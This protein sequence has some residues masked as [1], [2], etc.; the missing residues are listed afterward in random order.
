V[1]L[2]L[3]RV[4]HRDAA[5]HKVIEMTLAELRLKY[6][7]MLRLRL[8]H[9]GADEP[10]PRRDMATLAGRFPGALREIDELP[11]DEIEAR[12]AAID[13]AVIEPGLAAPWMTAMGLYH[14]LTRGALCA[15]RWLAGRKAIDEPTRAAFEGEASSLCYGEDALAWSSELARV[16]APPRGRVTDLVFEKIAAALAISEE[17]ARGLVFGRSRA[18]RGSGAGTA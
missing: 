18:S 12:I 17:E 14:A 9:R 3:Q 1:S 10:D 11:L 4:A 2:A 7:E 5:G 6:V 15:K 16:A 8:A 13:A